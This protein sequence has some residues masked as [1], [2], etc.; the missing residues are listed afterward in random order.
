MCG[1][2]D[3]EFEDQDEYCDEGDSDE[4]ECWTEDWDG[5][6]DPDD[7]EMAWRYKH[8]T[9]SKNCEWYWVRHWKNKSGA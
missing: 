7:L 6:D 9:S 5:D 4:E 2:P 3:D 1:G 8:Q